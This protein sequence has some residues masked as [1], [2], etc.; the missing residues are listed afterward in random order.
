MRGATVDVDGA[1]DGAN[2]GLFPFSG[3]KHFRGRRTRY[4]PSPCWQW[5]YKGN[6]AV[7]SI[8]STS[9]LYAQTA[10]LDD[11]LFDSVYAYTTAHIGE[12]VRPLLAHHL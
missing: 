6:R 1:G 7:D 12:H 5:D 11:E 2:R 3:A 10:T 9:D 8:R 4:P